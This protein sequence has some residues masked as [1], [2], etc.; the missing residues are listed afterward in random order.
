MDEYISF[1][2]IPFGSD[3]FA[4][5]PEPRCPCVLLLDTSGSMAGMPLMQLNEGV[6]TFKDEL[7]QD[8]LATKRVEVAIVTFGP[9]TVE[10][11]F[12][13][14]PNFH[15]RE[16]DTTGDTPMG[17]AILKGIDMIAKRKKEYKEHGISYYKPWIILI[18]DGAPTDE[19][20]R[21]AMGV[22]EGEAGKSFAFFAIGVEGANMDILRQIS[23]RAPLKL[24]GL[25]FREF[26][27][28]LSA[29]MKMVS[30]KNPG[31]AISLLP[32]SGWS[33]L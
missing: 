33:E 5:N 23:V 6:K 10:S 14:V 4:D 30:S 28:W 29:S 26:F 18:T 22:R 12:H 11:D 21:A 2:Q 15:P 3:N 16:L 25:M 8:S 20:N 17:E 19:W 7:M 27:M 1:E 24:K 9:V 32:P 13:T 31:N